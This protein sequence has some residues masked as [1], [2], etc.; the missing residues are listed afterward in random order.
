MLR[1]LF[2]LAGLAGLSAHAT[3]LPLYLKD[4]LS[5]FSPDIPPDLA[6]TI[7]TQR[8]GASSVE[9]YD[10]SRPDERQWTLLQRD[11]RAA[12]AE[13]NAR[14]G[15]YRTTTAP[16]MHATFRRDDID[17]NSLRLIR[18]DANRAEFEGRF[19]DDTNDPL[20]QRLSL[21][22]TVAKNPAA[23]EQCVLQ[24]IGTFSPVLT[25]KMLE[26]RVE[27]TFSPPTAGRPALP[28][29]VTSRFRG[30]VFLLKAIE[31]DVQT[32][33]SDFSQVIPRPQPSAPP[34]P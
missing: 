12:T 15:S 13:E 26:L 9:R 17:L 18:E 2:F 34:S 16:S 21:Q 22:L 32:V 19:R 6:Y 27:T 5:R 3:E 1:C 10:P 28:R 7:T 23:I 4:A 29:R 31:E 24:L 14:L 11:S 30:R 25:V 8:A 20:L 33:Y